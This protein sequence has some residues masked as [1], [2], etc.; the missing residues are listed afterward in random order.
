MILTLYTALT[1]EA[2]QKIKACLQA[3]YFSTYLQTQK[4]ILLDILP[5]T[6]KLL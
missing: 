5:N 6:I 4:Y 3:E 1:Q 2:L